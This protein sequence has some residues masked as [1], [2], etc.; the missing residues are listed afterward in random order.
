MLPIVVIMS[1]KTTSRLVI[2]IYSSSVSWF[3]VVNNCAQGATL[4][5]RVQ[6]QALPS[7]CLLVWTV[8][9]TKSVLTRMW[10]WINHFQFGVC[11]ILHNT[12]VQFCIFKLS[13][14][15]YFLTQFSQST[16]THFLEIPKYLHRFSGK[17]ISNAPF[18]H[19]A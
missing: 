17:K 4:R 19:F 11:S 18:Y 12:N 15:Y 2:R 3:S 16:S 10:D 13:S 5:W 6:S 8:F 7:S 14:S 9:I 1:K